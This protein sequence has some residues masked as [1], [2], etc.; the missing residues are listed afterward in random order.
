MP[1]IVVIDNKR[2]HEH[3]TTNMPKEKLRQGTFLK[4]SEEVEVHGEVVEAAPVVESIPEVAVEVAAEVEAPAKEE[5]AAEVVA[6]PVVAEEVK[7]EEPK[8]EA[9]KKAEK[10]E[11]KTGLK[12]ILGAVGKKKK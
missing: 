11:K 10:A 6:A 9:P 1:V 8:V 5:V 3:T 2:N 12:K 7:A 4:K